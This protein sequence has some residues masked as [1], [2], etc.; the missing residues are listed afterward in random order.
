M[1]VTTPAATDYRVIAAQLAIQSASYQ[2]KGA[3]LSWAQ[4]WYDWLIFGQLSQ[5]K[6]IITATVT[7]KRGVIVYSDTSTGGLM[8][9]VSMT[10][11]DTITLAANET[12]DHGD[13]VTTDALQFASSDS[14]SVL[15]FTQSGNSWTGV[16][17]A[18][19]SA[20]VTISDPSAP[21][22]TPGTVDITVTAGAASSIAVSA[23]VNTGANVS[24]PAGG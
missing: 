17:V 16:P 19:G 20:Q 6:I 22:L 23:T 21:T 2:N 18:E 14:G 3:M 13:P 10:M 7:G 5:A 9:P 11:D 8:A 12:D 15:T 4:F 1:T 24:P